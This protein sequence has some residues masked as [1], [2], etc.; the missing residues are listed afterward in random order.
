MITNY[1]LMNL[2]KRFTSIGLVFYFTITTSLSF[3][4]LYMPEQPESGPGGKDYKHLSIDVVAEHAKKAGG[5]WL[6]YPASPTPD[7]ANIVVFI[8]GFGVPNPA[9]YGK[10]IK[11]LV[12][13]GNI[14]IYPRYQ[15]KLLKPLLPGFVDNAVDG[16]KS[17]FEYLEKEE[18]LTPRFENIIYT[19]HSYGGKIAAYLTVNYREYG[20]PK[21]KALL[22]NQPGL[23][24]FKAAKL[25]DYT[26]MDE[27]IKLLVIIGAKDKIVGDNLGLLIFN[28]AGAKQKNLVIQPQDKRYGQEIDGS[29]DEPCAID[30]QLDAIKRRNYVTRAAFRR[31]ESDVADFYCYW[32]LLDA[33]IDCSFNNENCEYAFGNTY[34]QTYMGVWSDGHAAEPLRIYKE[35]VYPNKSKRKNRKIG[36]PD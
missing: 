16:I 22:A 26:K 32:K 23:I 10:W 8:P 13:K 6:Y 29:H 35:P 33:L 3:G 12:G 11:H 7:S 15:Q 9:V 4:Q 5:F 17:A 36:K 14:V 25:K 19:G 34:E 27:D 30:E 18:K 31:C 21:P 1:I 24:A 28:T 20:V 2:L